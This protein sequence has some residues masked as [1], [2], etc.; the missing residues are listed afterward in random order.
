MSSVNI[1]SPGGSRSTALFLAGSESS[2]VFGSS[3]F[4]FKKTIFSFHCMQNN[5]NNSDDPDGESV[6]VFSKREETRRPVLVS[7]HKTADLWFYVFLSR[8]L[9]EP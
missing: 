5:N 6:C 1:Y 2:S 9:T 4:S 8:V 7:G 3:V